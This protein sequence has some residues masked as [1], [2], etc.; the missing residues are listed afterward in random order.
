MNFLPKVIQ[1]IILNYKYQL[2]H[3]TKF[4][5]CIKKIKE[6]EYEIINKDLSLRDTD[7]GDVTYS[8]SCYML[9]RIRND[10]KLTHIYEF[11]DEPYKFQYED[12]DE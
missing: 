7:Y 2:E 11:N 5:K 12:V 9:F 1:D 4:K 10:I 3:T 6:I 8:R